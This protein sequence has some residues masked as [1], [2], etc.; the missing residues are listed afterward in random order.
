M[1]AVAILWENSR[2]S[3][4]LFF[5]LLSHIEHLLNI[6]KQT[7]L[8]F[9]SCTETI[10]IYFRGKFGFLPFQSHQSCRAYNMCIHQENFLLLTLETSIILLMRLCLQKAPQRAAV[11]WTF[12]LR[13][14]KESCLTEALTTQLFPSVGSHVLALHLHAH[15][16]SMLCTVYSIQNASHIP[17]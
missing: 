13:R 7:H 2:K 15:Q 14:P 1:S 12:L 9:L 16:P 4:V 6:L 5:L 11:C 10:N 17:Y 8:A 3:T